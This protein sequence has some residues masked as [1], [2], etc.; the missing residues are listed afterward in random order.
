MTKHTGTVMVH[1]KDHEGALLIDANTGLPN[2]PVD[3]RP[4]WSDGYTA[5][6]L[7]ERREF[8]AKRL[9]PTS[10][11]EHQYPQMIDT[12]DLGWIAVDATGSEFEIEA[13][14]EHR[15]NV[16]G[17]LAGVDM[18]TGEATGTNM[19][20]A[21]IALDTARTD[22]QASALEQSQ[23]AGFEAGLA[24]DRVTG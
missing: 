17:E 19:V 24:K 6:L 16:I 5:A 15:M 1:K 8:Y 22:E 20:T 21:E 3:E 11:D 18:T 9:G 23:E 14:A 7:N 12:D 10:T 2:G 4:E 13:S